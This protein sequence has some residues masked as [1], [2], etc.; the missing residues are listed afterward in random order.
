MVNAA[1]IGILLLAGM[2][3]L[4]W[5]ACNIRH[6][7]RPRIRIVPSFFQGISDLPPNMIWFTDQSARPTYIGHLGLQST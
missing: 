1:Q 7:L 6:L 3:P 2:V 5:F 4:P